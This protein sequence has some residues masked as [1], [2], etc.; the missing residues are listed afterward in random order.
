ME[1]KEAVY[2]D[3]AAT[4]GLHPVAFEAMCPYFLERYGNPSSLHQ[5]GREA[6]KAVVSARQTIASLLS[7]SPAS[8]LFTS[9]GTESI[10]LALF[11]YVRQ[12]GRPGAHIITTEIE[13][14]AVA[15]AISE[16]EQEGY[17]VTRLPVNQS[18]VVSV[19]AIK[20]V[21]T[22][23]T[24]LVSIMYA[25]NET[26]ALAPVPEIGRLL[27]GH[28]AVFH[29]DAVQAASS[30]LLDVDVLGV[31]LMS[32][33]SHK[34]N[35]PKG[36]GCLYV[37]NGIVLKPLLYGGEQE[38]KRRAGTED[39]PGIVGFAKAFAITAEEQDIRKQ[40]YMTLRQALLTILA[41]E[42][43]S[44][45]ING[46][47]ER[48]LAHILNIHFP[49]VKT[50][51]LL[52]QLDLAGIAVSGGSAC[53]AGTLEPSHVLQSMYGKQSPRVQGSIRISFGYTN[54]CAEATYVGTMLAKYV[55]QAQM[56]EPFIQ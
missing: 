13:H 3:H 41:R 29:T 17:R 15:H 54:T 50:E 4:S 5:F 32:I 48:T 55:R 16:L 18:G 36:V 22:D 10:N 8:V 27:K 49:K 43:V 6:K 44:Y 31:D 56:D 12:Y 34:V 19:E 47:S 26:G 30:C 28:P 2:M 39:V 38:Q 37:R 42:G 35:G 14:H 24:V 1:T 25:N 23:D 9:G 52:A 11:G 33:S 21:L 40:H 53:T 46:T 20:R 51:T 45:E 7:A